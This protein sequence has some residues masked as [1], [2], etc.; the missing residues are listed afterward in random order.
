MFHKTSALLQTASAVLQKNMYTGLSDRSLALFARTSRYANQLARSELTERGVKKLL[1]HVIH[2]E[3]A[4]AKAMIEKS[5]NLLLETGRVTDYSG[6]TIEG[7]AFQLA[8][9]AEDV[10]TQDGEECMAEMIKRYLLEFYTQEIMTEQYQ[11][12]FPEGWEIQE[13]KRVANDL[14]A[15]YKVLDAIGKAKPTDT[16]Y[17][18][19]EDACE[20]ALVEFREYLESQAKAGIIKTGKHCNVQ[21]LAEAFKLYDENYTA[22]GDSWDSPKNL[23][24]WRKVCGFIQRYLPTCYAQAFS[25]GICYISEGKEPLKRSLEFRND[26]GCF[27][28]PLGVSRSGLGFNFAVIFVGTAV[29]APGRPARPLSYKTYFEQK[30]QRSKSYAAIQQS[31]EARVCRN[32]VC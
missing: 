25:Q 4:E 21:L 13:E 31:A 11:A 29:E 16:S 7:T 3:Q 23:L 8:L 32:V 22:F 26:P 20:S 9:G 18:A 17:K 19:C 28:F 1:N 2:G 14:A 10:A 30:R 27:F 12:Q 15:L 6:R 5:P 24:S